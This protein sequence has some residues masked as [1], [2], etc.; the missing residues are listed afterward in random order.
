LLR[1]LHA[2]RAAFRHLDLDSF[3]QHDVA[4]HRSIL[5]TKSCLTSGTAWLSTCGFEEKVS[6]DLPD[7]VESHQPIVDALEKGRG[8]EA[9]LLL[10]NH[11]ETILEFLTKSDSGFHRALTKD[12]ENAKDV[13]KAFFP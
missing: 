2:M 13:Q 10:R 7:V 12:L 6:R 11:V 3:A 5:R 4:F 1:E 9:G 8:R